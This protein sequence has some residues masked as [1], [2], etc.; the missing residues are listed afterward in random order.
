MCEYS[1]DLKSADDKIILFIILRRIIK[2]KIHKR[3]IAL[4]YFCFG[5]DSGIKNPLIKAEVNKEVIPQD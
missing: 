5:E 4:M 2:T 1:R 3:L